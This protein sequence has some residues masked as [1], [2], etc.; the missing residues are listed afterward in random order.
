MKHSHEDEFKGYYRMVPKTFDMLSSIISD[1]LR[2]YP[3]NRVPI[4]PE[5]KRAMTIR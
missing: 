3:G 1:H 5:E 2:K 4:N